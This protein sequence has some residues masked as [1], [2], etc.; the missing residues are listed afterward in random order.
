MLSMLEPEI[1]KLKAL[2]IGVALGTVREALVAEAPPH[3][4]EQL[5]QIIDA[6]TQKMGGNPVPSDD[7]P[8]AKSEKPVTEP[9]YDP[10]AF[11]EKPRW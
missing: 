9:G 5:G 4:A 2:A 1:N 10:A 8:F 11:Q 3:L 7:L 6:V